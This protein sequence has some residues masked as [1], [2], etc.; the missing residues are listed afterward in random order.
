MTWPIEGVDFLEVPGGAMVVVNYLSDDLKSHIRN[1]LG[2]LC[3]GKPF[4]IEDPETYSFAATAAEFIKRYRLKGPKTQLGMVGEL[5]THLF[6]EDAFGDLASF[7]P[8]FNKE[9]RSIK[10]GFDLTFFHAKDKSIWYSEVKSGRAKDDLPDPKLHK[11]ARKAAL[12]LVEKIASGDRKSLWYS[13]VID[14]HTTLNSFESKPVKALLRRDLRSTTLQPSNLILSAA[15]FVPP[16]T[17][18][19]TSQQLTKTLTGIS[20]T[21]APHKVRLLAIQKSTVERVVEFLETEMEVDA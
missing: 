20:A 18:L 19:M 7:S 8:Y 13:A 12:D 15:V 4:V 10:K 21:Y 3:H 6:V 1:L 5:L 11:L 14:A 2:Q 16:S 9:E 17:A